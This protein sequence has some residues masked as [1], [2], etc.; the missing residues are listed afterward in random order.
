MTG[1][2]PLR[3]ASHSSLSTSG[4]ALT[5]LHQWKLF[6]LFVS[7]S[8]HRRVFLSRHQTVCICGLASSLMVSVRHASFFKIANRKKV[9]MFVGSRFHAP[10]RLK[11]AAPD[12]AAEWD[13][14]RNPGHLFPAIVGIGH[15]DTVWWRCGSC[16]TPY[17][18][19]VEKRVVRGG[20]CPFCKAS[21][22]SDRG[23]LKDEEEEG[24]MM[25]DRLGSKLDGERDPSLRAKRPPMFGIR[26]KY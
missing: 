23:R 6:P 2:T 15:M 9:E 25:D 18:M 7:S 22:K 11:T 12:I 8:F 16:D 20:G 1:V 10:T 13:W 3:S 19:S 14:E 4:G 24:E 5:S 17:Q 26:T 21:A